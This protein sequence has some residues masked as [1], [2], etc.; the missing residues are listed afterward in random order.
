[1]SDNVYKK[2]KYKALSIYAILLF[3]TL[4][5]QMFAINVISQNNLETLFAYVWSSL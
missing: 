2:R 1:M 4:I 5:L 3:P